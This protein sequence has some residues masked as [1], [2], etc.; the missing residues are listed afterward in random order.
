[1]THEIIIL[2]LNGLV[3][4]HMAKVVAALD[5]PVAE[6]NLVINIDSPRETGNEKDGKAEHWQKVMFSPCPFTEQ[7]LV[8]LYWYGNKRKELRWELSF[9]DGGSDGLKN[10]LYDALYTTFKFM[11]RWNINKG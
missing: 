5:D 9:V 3:N 6:R 11:L 8:F 2:A 1:M 10:S 4:E 7:P